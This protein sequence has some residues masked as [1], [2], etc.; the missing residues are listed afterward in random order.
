MSKKM[1]GAGNIVCTEK[2]GADGSHTSA[3]YGYYYRDYSWN[4][5]NLLSNTTDAG[6]S[7]DYLYG[8]D[9]RRAVK[10]SGW[11]EVLYFNKFFSENFR[12]EFTTDALMTKN[13]FLGTERIV[14][15]QCSK[16]AREGFAEVGTQSEADQQYYYHADHLGSVSAITD[17]DGDVYERLEYTPYGEVWIDLQY[18]T[19]AFDFDTPYKFT[20]KE[21]D[22]ETGLYYYGARYL[23]PMY[24]RWLS[25][26]PALSDY[27]SGSKAG[28]GIYNSHNFN[29]YNYANNNPIRYTDPDGRVSISNQ[30]LTEDPNG[31]RTGVKLTETRSLVIHWTGVPGQTAQQTR[32]FF[33]TAGTS[34]HYVIGQDG[35]IIRM[36]PDDEMA[37]HAGENPSAGL[38]YTDFANEN[39]K[40]SNGVTNPNRFTIGIEVNPKD[41]SG[42]Y[43][44][45][46]RSS[47]VKLAAHVISEN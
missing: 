41:A 27:A 5:R 38:T 17:S 2:V 11:S 1:D 7:T 28:G 35:E 32:N 39:Y 8:T 9:G 19:T 13:I 23:D 30:L 20:G 21:L 43:T 44:K 22:E 10:R 12:P 40:R 31:N 37:Y 42:N 16:D 34:A 25:T 26:D 14:T 36:I 29:L 47:A 18:G 45:E 24:S 6:L 33:S 3:T 46:A 4:E 15:K